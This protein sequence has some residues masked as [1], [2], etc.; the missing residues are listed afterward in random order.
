MPREMREILTDFVEGKDPMFEALK[1]C[2]AVL[3]QLQ[4]AM[5]LC[6]EAQTIM[7]QGYTGS[8]IAKA[9]RI[10]GAITA[11]GHVGHT[12]DF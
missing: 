12:D 8:A 6:G 3:G 1:A 11:Q 5:P 9:R 10:I 2:E 4:D 7:A